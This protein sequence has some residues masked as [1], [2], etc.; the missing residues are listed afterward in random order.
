MH[1]YVLNKEKVV[2]YSYN[3][4]NAQEN[5]FLKKIHFIVLDLKLNFGVDP[6]GDI[7]SM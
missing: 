7:Q 2:T 4:G 5:W 3:D 1:V 6:Q